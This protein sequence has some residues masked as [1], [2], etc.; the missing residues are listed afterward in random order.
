M[1]NLQS[2]MGQSL[3]PY[4]KWLKEEIIRIFNS[5]KFEYER[6]DLF[7][8]MELALHSDMYVTWLEIYYYFLSQSIKE[9]TINYRPEN[10]DKKRLENLDLDHIASCIK[11]NEDVKDRL[12]AVEDFHDSYTFIFNLND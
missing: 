7:R 2:A 1:G 12:E 4:Q 8:L 5:D 9:K 10:G 11:H 3:N 6:E